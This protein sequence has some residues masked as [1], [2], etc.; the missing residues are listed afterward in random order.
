MT[1]TITDPNGK[2]LGGFACEYSG[3]GTRS[4]AEESLA[5]SIAGMIKRRGY[6]NIIGK[7]C[8]RCRVG[9]LASERI[10]KGYSPSIYNVMLRC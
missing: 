10:S 1:T 6:G 3:S 2:Y 8:G 7:T 9:P 4:E 5:L